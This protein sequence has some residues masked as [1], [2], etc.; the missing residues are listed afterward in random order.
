VAKYEV[1]I[2]TSAAKELE[3]VPSRQDRR[4]IVERIRSLSDDAR[5]Q[6]CQKLSGQ[7]K[8]RLRQG[9]YRIVYEIQ[10]DR[11]IV[12]IV[13]IAHRRDVYRG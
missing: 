3:N 8:Y 11:L 2:K 10:D 9:M 6:V 4:R 7:E 5:P 1:R 12:Q 13:R